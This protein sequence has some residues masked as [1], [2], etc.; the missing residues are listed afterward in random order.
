MAGFKQA[1]Q[2]HALGRWSSAGFLMNRVCQCFWC[3]EG[4]LSSCYVYATFKGDVDIPV[5]VSETR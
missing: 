5:A 2:I 4:M 1:L 3:Q